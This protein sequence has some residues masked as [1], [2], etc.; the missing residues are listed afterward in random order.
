[1]AKQIIYLY[2][3]YF[4]L[5]QITLLSSLRVI[6]S[7]VSIKGKKP[8]HQ[9]WL[10][11][12]TLPKELGIMT[13]QE[14]SKLLQDIPRLFLTQCFILHRCC[15]FIGLVWKTNHIAKIYN[16]TLFLLDAVHVK[17]VFFCYT[18]YSFQGLGSLRVNG[19]EKKKKRA[20]YR[21]FWRQ[22]LL[23]D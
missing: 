21:Y 9:S 5:L 11:L 19:L 8:L 20:R 14:N 2:S 13:A 16:T 4:C 23:I 18:E 15:F 7:P 17:Q 12:G 6:N 22:L 10:L 3:L 1:M